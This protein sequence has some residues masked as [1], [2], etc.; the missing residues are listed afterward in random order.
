MR[1][2]LLALLSAAPQ[3]FGQSTAPFKIDTAK[4]LYRGDAPS[5]GYVSLTF[6]EAI[7]DALIENAVGKCSDLS[8][9]SGARLKTTTVKLTLSKTDN[10]QRVLP[11]NF[12]IQLTDCFTGKIPLGTLTPD[13][14]P[15]ENE[16]KFQMDVTFQFQGTPFTISQTGPATATQL[17][18]QQ[19][20]TEAITEYNKKAPAKTS[21][22]KD[23]FTGLSVTVP[24]GG[25]NAQGNADIILNKEFGQFDF[26]SGKIFDQIVA[27]IDLKKGSQ[28]NTD[29]KHFSTGFTFRKDFLLAGRKTFSGIRDAISNRQFDTARNLAEGLPKRPFSALLLDAGM[30]FEADIKGTGIGNISN[31]IFVTES[32]LVSPVFGMPG[33]K[34]AAKFT[35]IPAA[36]E[37]GTNLQDPDNPALDG[38]SVGRFKSGAAFNVLLDS[39]DTQNF[40]GHLELDLQAVNRY[41]WQKETAFD[42]ATQLALGTVSGNKY[43]AEASLKFLVGST[44]FGRPG[45]K[46]SF[47]RGSLPPVY[48]FTKMFNF[49]FIFESADEKEQVK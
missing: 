39:T 20:A 26:L 46:L 47:A 25:G 40:G 23:I 17:Q 11:E 2:L 6:D 12:N 32:R 7:P 28:P 38:H 14:A 13:Q 44:A 8:L 15:T 36:V 27:G 48:S 16:T 42:P 33:T 31:F 29:P 34:N 43:Y 4:F 41:L 5:K 45:F 24:S 21:N 18:V 37:V 22:D 30:Q 35:L 10:S 3:L 9:A 1:F 49:G 19:L